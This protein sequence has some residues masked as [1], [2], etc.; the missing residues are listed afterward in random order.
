MAGRVLD[1]RK[2]Y[3]AQRDGL[4]EAKQ[5]LQN[6]VSTLERKQQ[7]FEQRLFRLEGQITEIDAKRI[8]LKSMQDASVVMVEN[9][10]NLARNVDQLED[11]VLDLFADV[12][13]ELWAEDEKWN[14]ASLETEL[15][16]VDAIV[17]ATQDPTDI[18]AEI[19]RVLGGTE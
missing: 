18:I 2:D 3:V 6:V 14:A 7:G 10:E 12:Q 8:A 1:A 11:Q 17:A 16:S 9:E 4:R 15:I 13:A 5:S 19:D